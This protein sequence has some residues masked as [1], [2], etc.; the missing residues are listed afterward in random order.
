MVSISEEKKKLAVNLLREGCS[1]REV[2]IDVG[3]SKSSVS[4]IRSNLS[5]LPK[6]SRKGRPASLSNRDKRKVVKLVNDKN[7]D[8]AEQ[9]NR[10]LRANTHINVSTR[11]IRRVLKAE[12]YVSCRKKKK[13][14]LTKRHPPLE[15]AKTY[16]SWTVEDWKRVAFSDETRVNMIQSDGMQYCWRKRNSDLADKTKNSQ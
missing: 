10:E 11:T 3:I 4:R 8:T 5:D 2:A 1:V 6:V 15:F 9:V 16:S 13:P 14:L 12:G 7:V